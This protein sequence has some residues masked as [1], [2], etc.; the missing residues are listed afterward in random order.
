MVLPPIG[1][2][3]RGGVRQGCPL[4][5]QLLKLGAEMLSNR[6]RQTI[7]IKGIN[8]FGNQVKIGQFAA[9]TNQFWAEVTSVEHALSTDSRFGAISGLKLNVKK[10]KTMSSGKWSRN[11]FTNVSHYSQNGSTNLLRSQWYTS[12]MIKTRTNTLISKNSEI[13]E[14]LVTIYEIKTNLLKKTIQKIIVLRFNQLKI[15][16]SIYRK[17]RD[18]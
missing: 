16:P 17:Q 6:V 5:P 3:Q 13:T 11:L 2:K 10:T 14:E 4:F 8:L 12:P 15:F 7:G 9:D 1:L 18:F